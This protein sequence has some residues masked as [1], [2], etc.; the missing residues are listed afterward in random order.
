MDTKG[1]QGS[2]TTIAARS[3]YNLQQNDFQNKCSKPFNNLIL[4]CEE[5]FCVILIRFFSLAQQ[6][7]VTN[8]Y[9]VPAGQNRAK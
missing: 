1:D 5:Q 3:K 8:V 9:R 7:G 6:P 4:I 2:S